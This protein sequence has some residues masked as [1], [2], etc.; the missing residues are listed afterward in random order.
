MITLP[1]TLLVKTVHGCKGDFA[2]GTLITEVGEFKVKDTLLD[3]YA[4]GEYRGRFAVGRIFQGSYSWKGATISELRA[5]LTGIELEAAT[6]KPITAPEA[7]SAP[8]PI[9][10]R[11]S[12]AITPAEPDATSAQTGATAPRLDATAAR[13]EVETAIADGT[14]VKLDPTVDRALFR[15]QRDRLK[16]LGYR[17]DAALQTWM[18]PA[19]E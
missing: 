10:E 11:A 12:E 14:P 7:P 1:G 19:A 3:Q 5:N 15:A 6:E 4:E 16:G 2:V 13:D 8:D 9:E 18:P 17:F